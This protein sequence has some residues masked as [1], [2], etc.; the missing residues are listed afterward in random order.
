M[1]NLPKRISVILILT[2]LLSLFVGCTVAEPPLEEE[3]ELLSA[4]IEEREIVDST[5]SNTF[6]SPILH[7]DTIYALGEKTQPDGNKTSLLLSAKTS[8]SDL[9]VRDILFPSQLNESDVQDLTILSVQKN[10]IF[11]LAEIVFEE[12]SNVPSPSTWW[13]FEATFDGTIQKQHQ[14]E[15]S[16]TISK[17]SLGA[18]AQDVAWLI[19]DVNFLCL[20]LTTLSYKVFPLPEDFIPW[21]LQILE[22]GYVFANGTTL[23]G[24]HSMW[25]MTLDTNHWQEVFAPTTLTEHAELV[26]VPAGTVYPEVLCYDKNTL[27]RWDLTENTITPIYRWSDCGLNIAAWQKVIVVN[28]GYE[29]LLLSSFEIDKEAVLISHLTPA[30][31]EILNNRKRITV[32][33]S[34]GPISGLEELIAQFNRSNDQLFVQFIDYSQQNPVGTLSALEA[35]IVRGTVP[36]IL[37]LPAGMSS[38][39][40][41]EKGLFVDLYP[42]I[43]ADPKLERTDFVESLLTACEYNEQLPTI[44]PAYTLHTLIG[45]EEKLGTQNGWTWNT[46]QNI[47][48]NTPN[49]VTPIYQETR[50]SILRFQVFFGG[51]TFIDY[52]AGQAHFDTDAF[53]AVLLSCMQY[54]TQ[55][56]GTKE[57][58][59]P[60]PAIT[61]GES[62]LFL[63][64]LCDF[65]LIREMYYVFDG[66]IVYKGFPSAD[67]QGGTAI[68]PRMQV[69]IT[70]NC[71]DIDS[72]WQFVRMLLCEDFQNQLLNG[73]QLP[74]FPLRR[75]SLAQGAQEA[76]VETW[77]VSYPI[78]VDPKI[79]H[80][81]N[82]YWR[83]GIPLERSQ[84]L[85]DLIEST[86]VLYQ[87]DLFIDTILM[88]ESAT[89][90]NGECSID[91]AAQRIDTR[92]QTYLDERA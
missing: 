58:S 28:E 47:C 19:T 21:Q 25:V 43:D 29:C 71:D 84:R 88:E 51:N 7:D 79:V 5:L 26:T 64:S 22:G 75:D 35:A 24:T 31:K 38:S 92:I 6:Y 70:T 76:S 77:N 61:N 80:E 1:I 12:S 82:S 87:Y 62:F 69:A 90:F 91:I 57:I 63:R 44:V 52:Q 37:F 54:P 9:F 74:A 89:Y 73:D 13:I 53:K 45:A 30:G 55:D 78:Y 65:H 81:E 18:V 17:I 48:N 86:A 15:F 59:D 72:A 83:Q 34:G 4:L 20:D 33:S 68:S 23:D 41:T 42:L 14:L 2:L 10:R 66:E 56:L 49:L 8:G 40:Y 39:L 16:N 46:F 60:K 67:G 3:I 50:E 32:A 36:D 11:F 27:W 85:I